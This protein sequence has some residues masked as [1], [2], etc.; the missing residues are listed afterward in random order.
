[1]EYY[2][3]IIDIAPI[4]CR[5]LIFRL[6]DIDAIAATNIF[7]VYLHG[8][9]FHWTL[10]VDIYFAMTS[11]VPVACLMLFHLFLINNQVAILLLV[12]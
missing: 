2:F 7:V 12:V 5:L 9:S 1:M 3:R 8:S 11:P 4:L 6:I 10:S